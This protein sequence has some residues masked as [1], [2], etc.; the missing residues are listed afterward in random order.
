MK[1]VLVFVNPRSRQGATCLS[2][3]E[4]WLSERDYQILNGLSTEVSSFWVGLRLIPHLIRGKC[5]THLAVTEFRSKEMKVVTKKTIKVDIDSDVKT[6]TPLKLELITKAL[7]V[8]APVAP[9][10]P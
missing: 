5:P 8:L 9:S 4:S 1:K 10:D 2:Q 3:V 6:Q 7:K